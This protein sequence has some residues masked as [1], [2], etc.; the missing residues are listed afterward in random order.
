[1]KKL[2]TLRE[3]LFSGR[4]RS[5]FTLAELLIVVAII[6]ILVAVSIP[7]FTTQL[8]KAKENTDIANLRAAKA[9]AVAHYLGND[10]TENLRK[11]ASSVSNVGVYYYDAESGILV[12]AGD[13]N[14][15]THPVLGGIKGYGKGTAKDG[16]CDTFRMATRSVSSVVD[17]LGIQTETVCSKHTPAANSSEKAIYSWKNVSNADTVSNASGSADNNGISEYDG[18]FDVK[19]CVIKLVI[20]YDGCI[21]MTWVNRNNE[22]KSGSS[23]TTAP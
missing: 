7:V 4:S 20:H 11:A 18:V 2:R 14:E 12:S 6:G 21:N 10:E 5:A 22:P 17:D 3:R 19:N 1:M 13:D 23:T 9:A 8:E 16:G 15:T